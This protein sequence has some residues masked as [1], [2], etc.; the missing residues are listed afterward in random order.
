MQTP[1]IQEVLKHEIDALPDTLAES[2][3]DFVLFIK[4]RHRQEIFLW[5]QVEA[6]QA[7]R[8]QHPEKV[9]TV[10]SEEWERLTAHLGQDDEL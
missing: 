1:T 5:Q 10:T 8:Q 4:S 9:Q 2:V 7:Y 6:A 3:L